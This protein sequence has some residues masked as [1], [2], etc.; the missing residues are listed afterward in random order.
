MSMYRH[1]FIKQNDKLPAMIAV[2]E[3]SQIQTTFPNEIFIPAHWHRSLEISWIEHAQVVLEI[4]EHKQLIED[5]FTCINSGVV[6]SLRCQKIKQDPSC[7]IVI[8]SYEFLKQIVPEID[9]VYFDLQLQKDHSDLK[10]LYKKLKELYQSQTPYAYLDIIACLFEVV[11]LLMKNYQKPKDEYAKKTAKNQDQIQ[12]ILT[13]LQEHYD[14]DLS[15][16]KIAEQFHMSKE[17]F[18]R[19]FH[20]YVGKTYRDYV[21]SYRLYQAYHDVIHSDLCIQ[22]IA[23]KH[24]FVNVKSFIQAFTKS[25]QETPLKYRKKYQINDIK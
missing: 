16:Q 1:E 21:S 9:E 6:H 8:L 24:G 2:L 3:E 11:S 23:R 17:H 22:D 15:L 19:Q 14:Q 7:I 18:S 5:D 25:Y 4:G 20:H 13:Y 12:Q 10:I